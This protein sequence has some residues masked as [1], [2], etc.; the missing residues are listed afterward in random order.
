[1]KIENMKTKEASQELAK[2]IEI[3]AILR[4]AEG[5]EWD[6]AQTPE[7]LIPYLLEEAYEVVESINEKNPQKIKDELGDL[8]LHI[9]FQATIGNEN[10]SFHLKDSIKNIN[11]KLIRRHPHVFGD[12]KVNGVADIRKNWEEIKLKE[13]RESL[14]EGLPKSFPPL[15]LAR[16]IQERAAEVGF[17]WDDI[18]DVWNKI[19]EE[20]EELAEAVN[21]NNIDEIENEFG[22][23]LFSMVNLSRFLKINPDLA[24]KRTINKFTKRFRFIEEYLKNQNQ[25]F[26]DLTLAELDK[27]WD[28]AKH[29]EK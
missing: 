23:L 1:M 25:N 3:V 7:S 22:D 20:T 19:H 4:S 14:L 5:C 27:I 28:K 8:L 21:S 29:L 10:E 16:R 17:D 2:L 12:T 6:R 24:L 15:L 13:G 9:V 26:K 11:S 18:N